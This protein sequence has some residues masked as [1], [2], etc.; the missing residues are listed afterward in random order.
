MM[1]YSVEPGDQIFVKGY[2]FLFFLKKYEHKILIKNI[3]KSL[4]YKYSQK[5]LL[6]EQ[7]NLLQMHLKLLRK[8]QLKK[9]SRNT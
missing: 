6:I 1:R 5:P 7:N 9:P 3:R 8:E 4:R 2:G